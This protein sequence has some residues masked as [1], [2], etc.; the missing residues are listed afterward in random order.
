VEEIVA[1]PAYKTGHRDP[2]QYPRN[3]LYPQKLALTS[4]TSDGRLIGIV[5]SRTQATEFFSIKTQLHNVGR[6][7]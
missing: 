3:T 5:R 1:A 4:P 7:L 6:Y 2:L